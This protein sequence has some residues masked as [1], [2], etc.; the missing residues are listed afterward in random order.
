MIPEVSLTTDVIVGFPG[1]TEEDFFETVLI[2]KKINYSEAFINK[3]S[4]RAGTASYKLGD[5]IP[6]KEKERR[7]QILNKIVNKK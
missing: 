5:P 1:E 4:P 2:F 7:W 6:W 3:Y